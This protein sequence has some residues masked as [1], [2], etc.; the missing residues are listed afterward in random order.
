MINYKLEEEIE[1]VRKSSLLVAA[2]H[3]EIAKL[4]QPGITTIELDSVAE[5]FILDNGG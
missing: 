4:I 2:T 3:A 5:E 1:L